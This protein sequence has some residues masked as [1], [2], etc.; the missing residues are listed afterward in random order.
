MRSQESAGVQNKSANL[1]SQK[2]S[3]NTIKLWDVLS[4]KELRTL[5]GHGSTV[6]SVAWSVDGKTLASGSFDNMIILWSAATDDEVWEHMPLDQQPKRS[7]AQ[8]AK[9]LQK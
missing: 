4:G 2:T 8:A 5:S 7:K 9:S 3:E 6:S 1:F